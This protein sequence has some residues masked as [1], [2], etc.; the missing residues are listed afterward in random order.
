MTERI[1]IDTP[2]QVAFSVEVA[3]VGSRFLALAIDL[4]IQGAALLV[5]LILGAAAYAGLSY[6]GAL[7]G[8]AM[9][10]VASAVGAAALVTTF[11]LIWGYHI[12]FETW[13]RGQSPGKR[14]V[15][16]RVVKDN[17]SPEGFLD[18]TIRNVVRIAD[19]LPAS[20]AVGVIAMLASRDHKRLG[21]MA[22]GTL[23]VREP[24]PRS[25]VSIAGLEP[26]A[27]RLVADLVDRAGELSPDAR[28]ALARALAAKLGLPEQDD[29]EAAFTAL[30]RLRTPMRVAG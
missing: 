18:A 9:R 22:A 25:P 13:M 24:R 14:V 26:R 12:A 17:G 4:T 29:P 15:G 16:L 2:E 3:D 27:Q 1:T 5:L 30:A 28:G 11:L 7:R 8:T 19:M 23:V 6:G 20:Y 10:D 21:D